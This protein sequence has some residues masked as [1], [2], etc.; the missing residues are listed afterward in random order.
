MAREVEKF[1]R[2]LKEH[3]FILI[4]KNKHEIWED[5]MGRRAV[6]PHREFNTYRSMKNVAAQL[7]RIGIRV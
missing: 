1:R 6:L 2:L 4:R 7:A 3:G 5:D